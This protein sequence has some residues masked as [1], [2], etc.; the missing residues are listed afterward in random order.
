MITTDHT[1]RVDATWQGWYFVAGE[2]WTAAFGRDRGLPTYP[3]LE[4]LEAA[5]GPL[6]RVEPVS[7]DDAAA[8]RD[9][10]AALGTRAVTTL[11]SALAFVWESKLPDVPRRGDPQPDYDLAMRRL[12]AGREGSWESQALKELVWFGRDV[13]MSR[14]A[15]KDAITEVLER[16]IDGPGPYTEV[17]ASLAGIVSV[18]ADEH[19]P[20]GW[21]AVADQWL[22]PGGMAVEDTALCRGLLYSASQYA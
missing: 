18:L 6:R 3:D 14:T 8:M 11:A 7:A 5:R 15:S 4:E 17:A 10:L 2:G 13:S 21:R 20:Q 1:R 19:G 16:W 22:Q 12:T 9:A